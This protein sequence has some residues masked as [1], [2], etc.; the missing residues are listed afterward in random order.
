LVRS[1]F[2]ERILRGVYGGQPNDDANITPNLVNSFINDGVAVAAKKNYNDNFQLD[3]VGYTNNSF[4]STFK[5]IVIAADE[6]FLYKFS[7][8]QIPLGIGSTEGISRILFKDSS[9]NLSYPGVLLSENQVA[10][11]RSMRPIP[12]KVMCYPEGVFCYVITT[13]L[14]TEYTASVTI[15]S[16]GDASDLNSILN[17]PDDYL[18]IVVDYVKQ[19]LM[20]EKSVPKDQTN[21]GVEN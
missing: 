9:N 21:D 17:I 14:M 20:F 16:G 19:Q 1:V 2:I 10:I 4:Y 7:L 5:G 11:Q 15:I 8:P 6:N 18:P 3:G 12:N 13:L